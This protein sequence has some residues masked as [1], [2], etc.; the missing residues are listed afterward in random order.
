MAERVIR[1]PARG[2]PYIRA[3]ERDG[4]IGASTSGVEALDRA[5]ARRAREADREAFEQLFRMHHSAVFRMVRFALGTDGH[6][7]EDLTAETFARAWKA[8]PKYR[9]TGA[10]FVSWLYGIARHVVADERRRS[11]RTQPRADLPEGAVVESPDEHLDLV[12]AIDRLPSEQKLVI[13]LK[14]FSSL[15]NPEVAAL[16]GITPGAVNARQWRA[17]QSLR[18]TLGGERW[19]N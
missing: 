4:N 16:L 6:D 8:I 11:M 14:Y 5:L 18:E 17:L 12:A 9:D 2:R 19:P 1:L 10:P 13:E 7:A 15:T 3:A